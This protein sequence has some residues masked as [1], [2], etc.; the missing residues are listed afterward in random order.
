MRRFS[1]KSNVRIIF[2]Q[3]SINASYL[4]HLYNLFQEYVLTP[5]SIYKIT[6]TKTGKPRYSL[7]FSTLSLPCFNEIYESFYFKGKKNNSK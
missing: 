1:E 2:R 4:L 7:S 6:D 3:G 5:P